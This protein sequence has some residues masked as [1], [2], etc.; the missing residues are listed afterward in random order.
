VKRFLLCLVLS[1][2][3]VQLC[4]SPA[5]AT[6]TGTV[7]TLPAT[8]IGTISATLNASAMN[9]SSGSNDNGNLV[10]VNFVNTGYF[11]YGTTS[12]VYTSSTP[13]FG[14]S[15]SSPAAFSYTV[16]TLNPCTTYF[17]RAVASFPEEE[18]FQ[19]Q[20]GDYIISFLSSHDPGIRGLGVG[21]GFSLSGKLVNA[22]I[23]RVY[24]GNEITFTTTG[25]RV[26]VPGQGATGGST[27]SV[28]P[29]NPAQMANI[30]VQSAAI[31]TPKV[32]PGEKVDIT[33]SVANRGNSNGD[34]KVTLYVNGQEVES[35]G[36]TLSSGQTAPLHFYVS[37]N[38]P[39]TYS[40]Y[41]SGVSAGNFTVDLFTNNDILIYGVIALLTLGIAGVLYMVTRKRAA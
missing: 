17:A 24:Y 2:M 34:T 30:I 23:N 4:A 33:A 1:L 11:Q 19:K 6:P 8:D 7:T 36:I 18:G 20:N 32:A 21:M 37:R 40:V 16:T 35:Q 3:A 12:G 15:P 39:G 26:R 9:L 14:I 22:S 25:C 5:M 10:L 28:T 41:V 13:P 38:E 29:Q 27:G 31:A